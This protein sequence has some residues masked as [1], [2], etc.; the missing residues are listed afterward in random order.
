MLCHNIPYF[1]FFRLVNS[2]PKIVVE[3]NFHTDKFGRK[4]FTIRVW[5]A[6]IE[7]IAPCAKEMAG[8][9]EMACCVRGYHVY[10]EKWAAANLKVLVCNCWCVV[11]RKFSL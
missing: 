3:S 8:E 7:E 10:E 2:C 6:L 11:V 5:W 1:A 4:S 9:K